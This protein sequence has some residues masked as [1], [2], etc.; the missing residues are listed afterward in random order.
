M[1]L[2][3]LIGAMTLVAVGPNHI[4]SCNAKDQV[5][6]PEI[7][8]IR[9]GM[10]NDAQTRRGQIRFSNNTQGSVVAESNSD[11]SINWSSSD[12]EKL[13]GQD[14][15]ALIYVQMFDGIFSIDPFQPIPAAND[16]TAQ[17]L[18]RGTTLE[19]DRTQHGRQQ[20]DRTIELF[21]KLEQA[22]TNWLRDNG[23]YGVRVFTNEHAGADS[24]EQAAKSLPEPSAVIERPADMP[25]TKSREQVKSNEQSRVQGVVA[26][27][28][29]SDEPIRISMPHTA[30]PDVLARVEKR[31]EEQKAQSESTKVAIDK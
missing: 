31:N 27:M 29:Q 21:V 3:S 25:R 22:R 17:M 15:P 19:T 28:K 6:S 5:R 12:R 1:L 14:A 8:E 16:S 30:A 7:I 26:M 9:A 4:S 11:G 18:F 23:Y 10:L 24:Q 20:I 2:T 13:G